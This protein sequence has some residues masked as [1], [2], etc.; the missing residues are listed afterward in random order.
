LKKFVRG[1]PIPGVGALVRLG[2]SL[3]RVKIWGAAP[4]RGRNMVFRKMRFKGYD[5]TSKSPR[6]LDQTSPYLFRL[7]QEESLLHGMTIRFWISSSISEIF[8]AKL[9]SRPK[10]GQILHVFGP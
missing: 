5:F 9:P 7:T 2:D 4:P 1:A 10:L 8:A 3:A 6:S